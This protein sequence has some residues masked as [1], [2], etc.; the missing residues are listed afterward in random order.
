MDLVGA[1]AHNALHAPQCGDSLW[2]RPAAAGSTTAAAAT[3]APSHPEIHSGRAARTGGE[4]GDAS[5]V[6]AIPSLPARP[7]G[8]AGATKIGAARRRA[9]SAC[10]GN[11][12]AAAD[13]ARHQ[14][15][16]GSR[17]L[18]ERGLIVSAGCCVRSEFIGGLLLLSVKRQLL[19]AA[20]GQ[21]I[22][23]NWRP[24]RCAAACCAWACCA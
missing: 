9:F 23:R 4:P 11:V 10:G 12:R 7:A 21:L 13:G 16:V 8:S 2:G 18:A 22:L 1:L 14:Q 3:A 19:E 15:G 6:G 24:G 20:G 5:G 17:S